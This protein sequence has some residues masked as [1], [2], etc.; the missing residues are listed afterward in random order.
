MIFINFIKSNCSG[1]Y[2]MFV[3][4]MCFIFLFAIDLFLTSPAH[5][6]EKEKLKTFFIEYDASEEKRNWL[7]ERLPFA[8]EKGY[9]DVAEFLILSGDPIE[10]YRERYISSVIRNNDNIYEKHP[11]T[12]AIRKDYVDLSV[13]MIK[14]IGN[15][16]NL[17]ES[18][19]IYFA[20]SGMLELAE[21][22]YPMQIAI[23]NSANSYNI[24]LALILAGVDVN[25]HY[26]YFIKSPPKSHSNLSPAYFTPLT[27]AIASKKLDLAELLL[28]YK[29]D[30]DGKET[31]GMTPLGVAIT[32]NYI[33]GVL[34]LLSHGADPLKKTSFSSSSPINLAI[35]K[36]YL[37]I[38]DLL[39]DAAVSKKNSL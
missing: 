10:P 19:F 30:V 37:D 1:V 23:E 28:R 32:D 20:N 6:I 25:M 22:K 29:A 5:A 14:I 15:M 31:Y 12:T 39:L 3:K 26:T 21:R 36:G 13:L 4:K 35:E 34:F 16:N 11:L 17:C 38:V 9:L 18:K 33:E 2:V 27:S 8:I 7:W 24:V